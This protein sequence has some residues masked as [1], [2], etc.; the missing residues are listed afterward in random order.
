MQLLSI[1]PPSAFNIMRKKSELDQP[2]SYQTSLDRGHEEIATFPEAQRSEQ[3]Q[4]KTSSM[5]QASKQAIELMNQRERASR[6][7][8][9]APCTLRASISSS[10]GHGAVA[11]FTT[12][13]FPPLNLMQCPTNEGWQ[14]SWITSRSSPPR[15]WEDCT[16]CWKTLKLTHRVQGHSLLRSLACLLRKASFA[17]AL[18]CAHLFALSITRSLRSS[19]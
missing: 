18:R 9:V 6:Q 17:R 14:I 5:K 11:R 15:L 2:T 4:S 8:R 3:A 19:W 16:L 12:L 1:P 7:I 13:F 10:I